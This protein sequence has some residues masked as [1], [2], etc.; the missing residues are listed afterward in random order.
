MKTCWWLDESALP[1]LIWARQRILDDGGC[2]I[3]SVDGDFLQFDSVREA[4]LWLAQ[5]EYLPFE[6]ILKDGE[7]PGDTMPPVWD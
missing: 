7:I 3:L 4:Q 6:E 1:H 2:E 5:D